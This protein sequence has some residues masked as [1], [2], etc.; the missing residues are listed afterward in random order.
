[1]SIFSWRRERCYAYITLLLWQWCCMFMNCM[2]VLLPNGLYD[3]DSEFELVPLGVACCTLSVKHLEELALYF[4]PL[5]PS[6]FSDKT[7]A[8]LL[9]LYCSAAWI[10][11]R[12]KLTEGRVFPSLCSCWWNLQCR[13]TMRKCVCV[14]VQKKNCQFILLV[15]FLQ[16]RL[17]PSVIF[18][19]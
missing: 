13:R 6:S 4:L 12:N 16:A 17:A 9:R 8:V 1:M 5:P 3:K 7:C 2:K 15:K 18:I 10:S 19:G 14:A 11:R